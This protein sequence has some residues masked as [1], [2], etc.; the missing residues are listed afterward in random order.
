MKKITLWYCDA[1]FPGDIVIKPGRM[2]CI[3]KFGIT[4]ANKFNEDILLELPMK[5]QVKCKLAIKEGDMKKKVKIKKTTKKS[6]K[7]SK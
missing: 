3:E 5:V 1:P 6:T 2:V 7:K 4:I